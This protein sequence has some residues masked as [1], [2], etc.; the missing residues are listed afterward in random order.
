MK[1][2]TMFNL[3]IV[4]I[5]VFSLL[6]V[7]A[8]VLAEQLQSEPTISVH[9][10][11]ERVTCF[12][13][14]WGALLT[15]EIDDPGTPQVPDYEISHIVLG[16]NNYEEIELNG[17]FDI[18]PGY[19]VTVSDGNV[20]RQHTVTR[21]AVT[22]TDINLDTVSGIATPHSNIRV[23]TN[24]AANGCAHRNVIADENG[25]WLANFSIPV[26]EPSQGDGIFDV[27][28]ASGGGASEYEGDGDGTSV[29]WIVWPPSI[30]VDV[31]IDRVQG[32]DWPLGATVSFEIDDPLTPENPDYT[33]S[34]TVEPAEGDPNLLYFRFYTNDYD[35]KP[36]DIVTATDGNITKELIV[37]NFRI[38]D[39][40]VDLDIVYGIAEPGQDV[41]IWSTDA[42]RRVTADSS[43]NWF[44][45]FGIP[46]D[47]DSEQG[48]LDIR[49]GSSFDSM[50]GDEDWDNTRCLWDVPNHIFSVRANSDQVEGSEWILGST[51][52]IEIDDPATQ[53]NPDY[54]DT[55]TVGLADWDPSQ[56]Y[57]GI[58]TEGYD[59]KLGDLVTVSDGDITKQLTVSNFMITDV[60]L[61]SD[62]VSGIAS[63]GQYVNIWTCWQNDPCV[64]R[65]ET[66]DQD[67]NW[68]TDFAVP[69]EQDWE[70]ETADLRAGSWI[71]SSVSDYDG[72]AVMYGW[73]VPAVQYA[74]F[75]VLGQ[76]GVWIKENSE[77]LS[78]D[79]GANMVSAGPYLADHAEVTIGQD[80]RFLDPASR[81]LG[82]TVYL[83]R[84][85][86]V[87]D[88]Y[89][90]H[91]WGLGDVLGSYHTPLDL[92]LISQLPE[93]PQATP[94]TQNFNVPI[95]GTLT[96]ASGNYGKLEAKRGSTITFTGGIYNFREWSLGDNVKVYFTAPTEIRI[97][98]KLDI[99]ISAYV[100]P[101]SGSDVNAHD[102][103]IYVLGV[104][105]YNGRIGA[106]PKAAKFGIRNTIFA[107]IYVPNGTLWIREQS[108][109]TGAFFA[110]WVEIGQNVTLDLDN[111][112][113]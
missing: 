17:I 59:L 42:S 52:I 76:E 97:T 31:D 98:G 41:A 13:W 8:P 104:N 11:K 16:P 33:N 111:G 22:N 78:G 10:D 101:A 74:A 62:L 32:W 81:V 12:D 71:D 2:H 61:N 90:N 113:R 43:G 48:T 18:Q 108:A 87:Y 92:P 72:D 5:L 1:T 68:V 94:G 77:I 93:V 25:N 66:A 58:I 110:R 60:D 95:R 45:N 100:G 9:P 96:L 27:R 88:V 85:A 7:P 30:G 107:N 99:G 91:I 50:A 106:D 103:F 51:I 53:T 102:I 29:S 35:L 44:A 40:D 79:V 3:V 23:D 39:A 20:T 69:G 64:S 63:P 6:S 47:D 82:D 21:L 49:N 34:A 67:G 73:Y 37:T 15:L 36:G 57:F 75:V 80:V 56:T 24:C 28:L 4:S 109:A 55:A 26:S 46:G 70:Q 89:Y 65:D 54:A 86:E 19:L 84:G 112:W 105:G 38:T 83:R 14:P